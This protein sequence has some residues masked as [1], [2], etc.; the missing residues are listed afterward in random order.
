MRFRLSKVKVM[1]P[2]LVGLMLWHFAGFSIYAQTRAVEK[3]REA[4]TNGAGFQTGLAESH[5]DELLGELKETF[6]QGAAKA[7]LEPENGF[8]EIER[9]TAIKDQLIAENEKNQEYF[10]QVEETITGKKL[11]PEILGRHR[12][13]VQNYNAKY[14]ALMARLDAVEG[15]H[16]TTTGFFG[17]L[18]R[19]NLTVDFDKPVS[20]ALSFLEKNAPKPQPRRSFDPNN[21]PHRSL[22]ADN[23]VLPK[24]TRAEWDKALSTDSAATVS[25]GSG[26]DRVKDSMTARSPTSS[27]ALLSTAPPTSADLAETIEVKFT[28]Q[29]KALADSLNKNPV[30]IY[31]WVRNNIEFVP[32]WG[33]IQGAQ[34]CMENRAG[35]AFDTASLLIAL[36]RYSGIPARYQMGTIEVPIDKLKNWAGGFTNAEAAASFFASAGVPSVVR[37]VNPSGQVV[38]IRLEHVWVKAFVDYAPSGGAVNKRVNSWVEVDPSFKQYTF[39]PGLDLEAIDPTDF[40]ALINQLTATATIDPVTGSVTNVNSAAVL[41]FLEQMAQRRVNYLVNNLP[42]PTAAAIF[43]RQV[44]AEQ[45]LSVLAVT[46]GNRVLAR[47]GEISQIPD[48]LRHRVTIGLGSNPQTPD[49]LD[50]WT[51]SISL[52][53]IAGQNILLVYLPFSPSD[54]QAIAAIVNEDPLSTSRSLPSAVRLAP[55]LFVGGQPVA[56]GQPLSLGGA[57]VSQIKFSSPTVV[58]PVISNN[59]TVGET[60]AI[61]LDL[62]GVSGGQL[63]KLTQR[64]QSLKARLLA[65]DPNIQGPE[66][67]EVFLSGSILRWFSFLD[68]ANRT[69]SNAR[70]VVTVR[71]PSAGLFS[72]KQRVQTLFGAPLSTTPEAFNMDIDADVVASAARDGDSTKVIDISLSAGMLG[73]RLEAEIPHDM[74]SVPSAT[75]AQVSTEHVLQQANDE[76]IPIFRITSGNASTIIPELQVEPNDLSDIQDAINAGLEV[77]VPRR[78]VTVAGKSFLG[79]IIRDPVTGSAGFLISGGSNGAFVHYVRVGIF[80]MLNSCSCYLANVDL[81][82]DLTVEMVDAATNGIRKWESVRSLVPAGPAAPECYKAAFVLAF[83]ARNTVNRS[84]CAVCREADNLGWVA[85]ANTYLA[86]RGS[87]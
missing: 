29:I 54:A 39:S 22:K 20:A 77:T 36:L 86:G 3:Q 41:S 68:G 58:T 72:V 13:F 35:N 32:T 31:N 44:I 49:I 21:L 16:Q 51:Y 53:E 55:K 6:R 17:K 69:A 61:G 28:P 5:F 45:A 1:S 47:S 76:G 84:A 7:K 23:P 48:G 83:V 79:F 64:I 10:N 26:S 63:E 60:A 56:T 52:P 80:G 8:A 43:G 82:E 73:S 9:L 46:L 30:K 19:A 85:F 70:G 4:A 25:T 59:M 67:A 57:L 81:F 34:L 78:P 2:V 66:W 14:E 42:N 62:Q 12:E 24:L 40:Q 74:L 27:P 15:A 38:S 87:C 18:T 75:L 71:Y 50:Q 37:R 11:S 33:S 65:R